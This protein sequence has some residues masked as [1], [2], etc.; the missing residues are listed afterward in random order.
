MDEAKKG[1]STPAQEASCE[2]GLEAFAG[3]RERIKVGWC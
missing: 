1:F 2:Q 3:A